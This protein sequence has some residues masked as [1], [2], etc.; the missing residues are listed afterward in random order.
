MDIEFKKSGPL[1]GELTVPGDKSISHRAVILASL[2]KGES[3]VY[4]ISMGEDVKSTIRCMRR[5]GVEIVRDGE[6]MRIR[7]KG[8][9]GLTEPDDVLDCGNSGTT[10]RLLSGVA[11]TRPFLTVLTG[12]SSL[13]RRPMARVV[14]PLSMMGAVICGRENSRLAPLVIRGGELKGIEYQMEVASAQVKSAILL[15]ALDARGETVIRETVLSRDHMERMLLEMGANL[16]R[17]QNEIRLRGPCDLNSMEWRIPGDISSAAFWLAAAAIVPGSEVLV[18]DVGVNPTRAGVITVLESM[19]AEI[20]LEDYRI[21]N[22]EP[23]ADI[24]VKHSELKPIAIGGSIIPSLIDEIPVLAVAMA[25]AHGT[26]AV[27]D[28]VELRAK[29]SDRIAMIVSIL[30]QMGVEAA[31]TADGFVIHGRG[32]IPGNCRL[33]AGGDHRIAMASA[34]AGLAAEMP[35]MVE[36]F[37]CVD[38]SYPSFLQDL[39]ALTR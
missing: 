39:Q 26:S 24:L 18:R 35:V 22:G 4:K 37:N 9:A 21:I 23:V 28:A 32:K 29:E 12:D 30:K 11:A 5:F 34:V 3:V 16:E 31:E 2:A 17:N 19:G 6:V 27:R 14:K 36:D 7:G 8:Y 33:A 13:R 38:I 15:A 1:R 25:M 20:H 10:M